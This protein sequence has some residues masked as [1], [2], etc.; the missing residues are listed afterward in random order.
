[1]NTN[2]CA[3]IFLVALFGSS[4]VCYGQAWIPPKG[5]GAIAFNYQVFQVDNHLDSQGKQD[6]SGGK[7]STNSV[8][9]DFSYSFTDK[10]AFTFGLPFVTTKYDGLKPHRIPNGDGT[11]TIPLDDGKYHSAFQDFSIQ[12][13]YNVVSN[14]LQITPFVR[15]VIPSHNYEFFAHSAPG[16]NT[17]KLQFGL[18]AGR[19]L[20]PLIPNAY[21][22]GR[23]SFGFNEKI[24]D[25][26]ARTSNADLEFGYFLTPS[27]RLFGLVTGQVT[28]GGVDLSDITSGKYGLPVDATNPYFF[29]HDRITT[30]NY[31]NFG[32]GASYSLN[33]AIDVY[34]GMTHTL[35]GKNGHEIKYALTFG[36]SY[37]FQGFRPM[38]TQDGAQSE[39]KR[40]CVCAISEVGGK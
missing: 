33:Q 29:N 13:R 23:Y 20:D 34:G 39:Y 14:P 1:M 4:A 32:G 21:V 40:T 16:I 35:S 28:H 36:V 15:A 7:I 22:Q 31:L 38:R 10:L 2:F 12:V 18:Y 25:I 5:D 27:V 3:R 30:T 6:P 26:S 11:F 17:Q 24:L 8:I 19:V 9:A 37:G